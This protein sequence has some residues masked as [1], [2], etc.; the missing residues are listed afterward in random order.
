MSDHSNKFK[1]YTIA[2]LC[3]VSCIFL[4]SILYFINNGIKEYKQ[5][6]LLQSKFQ[7]EIISNISEAYQDYKNYHDAQ[8]IAQQEIFDKTFLNISEAYQDYKNYH[9]AQIDVQQEIVD[10]AFLNISEA[11]QDYKNYLDAQIATQQD[12]VDKANASSTI[13]R[14]ISV[15]FS[16]RLLEEEDMISKAEADILVLD[17]IREIKKIS[18]RIAE[19]ISIFNKKFINS[20]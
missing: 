16:T 8:I 15:I 7:E 3:L 11:Y 2:T 4:I 14:E 5:Q 6:I 17:S 13:L 18:P 19:M 1:N 10:K 9:D 12:I 20:R